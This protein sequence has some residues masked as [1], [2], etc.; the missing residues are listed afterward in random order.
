MHEAN[1]SMAVELQNARGDRETDRN[2]LDQ[3]R[4]LNERLKAFLL[5]AGCTLRLGPTALP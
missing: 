1:E 5:A 3:L 2:A 4:R